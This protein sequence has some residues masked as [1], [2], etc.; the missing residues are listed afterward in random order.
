[1]NSKTWD[2]S[3]TEIFRKTKTGSE[4]R[5]T[6]LDVMSTKV[7]LIIFPFLAKNPTAIIKNT[8]A[9]MFAVNSMLSNKRFP[10]Q[11]IS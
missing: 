3:K 1:M 7:S 2:K 8:G 4:I 11:F 6:N 5:K 9:T 10:S